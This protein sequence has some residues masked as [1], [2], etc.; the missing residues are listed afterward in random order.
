[1][2]MNFEARA[3]F[4]IICQCSLTTIAEPPCD[5][6]VIQKLKRLSAV[7]PRNSVIINIIIIIITGVPNSRSAEWRL[8]AKVVGAPDSI[9]VGAHNAEHNGSER[10]MRW[11]KCWKRTCQHICF[12]GTHECVHVGVWNKNKKVQSDVTRRENYL[13]NSYSQHIQYGTIAEVSAKCRPFPVYHLLAY[14]ALRCPTLFIIRLSDQFPFGIPARGTS[15]SALRRFDIPGSTSANAA[16]H[17][18]AATPNRAQHGPTAI[19][20]ISLGSDSVSE[21]KCSNVTRQPGLL[22]I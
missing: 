16:S 15:H 21:L 19:T 4:Q 13:S 22:V 18:A 14:L 6:F 8:L 20:I 5:G 9:E 1:V 11:M 17:V 12:D 7:R 3:V 10:R 2:P